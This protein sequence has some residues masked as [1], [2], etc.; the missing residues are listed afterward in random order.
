MSEVGDVDMTERPVVLRRA[1]LLCHFLPIW[2]GS[3]Q[4]GGHLRLYRQRRPAQ[5]RRWHTCR[6]RRRADGAALGSPIGEP[7]KEGEEEDAQER[8]YIAGHPRSSTADAPVLARRAE[9]TGGRQARRDTK[10]GPGERQHRD[11]KCGELSG[12]G[13]E[14]RE[15]LKS[16]AAR[17]GGWASGSVISAFG[18]GVERRESVRCVSPKNLNIRPGRGNI[19]SRSSRCGASGG[20]DYGEAKIE[21][22]STLKITHS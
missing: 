21:A 8:P 16:K 1:R 9:S 3:R 11:G 2:Q 15:E 10:R 4:L 19:A 12:R 22:G 5:I 7:A 13:E 20:L 18:A 17:A 6:C 14:L